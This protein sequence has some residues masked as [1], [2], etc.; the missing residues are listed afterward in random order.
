VET[1][2]RAGDVDEVLG[3]EVDAAAAQPGGGMTREADPNVW[4]LLDV[5]H[6][7]AGALRE[8]EARRLVQHAVE[9]LRVPGV[10]D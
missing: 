6:L 1:V 4:I 10:A 2:D 5:V 7:G 9:D 8:R 3:A